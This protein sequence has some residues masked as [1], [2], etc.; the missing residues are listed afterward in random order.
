MALVSLGIFQYALFSAPKIWDVAAGVLLVS[1]AGGL[2][3]CQERRSRGWQVL[4]HFPSPSG[5]PGKEGQMADWSAPLLVGPP[6]VVR[7]VADHLR[8]KTSWLAA[9]S[10]TF[11]HIAPHS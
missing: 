9:L 11:R 8:R 4:D 10:R 3:L 1:E 5:R 7:F 6:P 2:V